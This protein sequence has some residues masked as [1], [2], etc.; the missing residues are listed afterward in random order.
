[1]FTNT[2]GISLNNS[3]L[4]CHNFLTRNATKSIKPSK[5]SYYSLESN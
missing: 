1:M 2:L 3:R 4:F 5:N